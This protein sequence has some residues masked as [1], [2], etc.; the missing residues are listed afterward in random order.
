MT[1]A[2][3]FETLL[4]TSLSDVSSVDELKAAVNKRVL[5]IVNDYED[6]QWRYSRFQSYLWDNIAETALSQRER[7]ALVGKSHTTL[8]ES[9]KNLRLTD[10]DKVGQGSEI[11]EVFLYGVMKDHFGA[12]PVVPKIFYKQ[13][14]QDNAKGADSVHIVIKDNDFTLWFGEAKFYNS[15]A[16]S[17]LDKIVSSVI[18]SLRTDKLKKENSIV[19]NVSD[20][21]TL[22]IDSELRSK[23]IDAIKPKESIDKIKNKINIPIMLLYE[24]S[25]TSS[26][27]IF[28]G[29]YRESLI[30]S[31]KER[32]E[33]YFKKQIAAS[34]S[35]F[36]YKEIRFHVIFFPVPNKEKIVKAFI[37]GVSFFKA[38]S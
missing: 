31:Q 2:I 8:V 1:T 7:N 16:D 10:N 24:C 12:L 22:N 3:A 21:H 35:V 9:A 29:E 5:S 4:D 20:I 36:L 13:N 27:A 15:L 30:S 19:T 25:L 18:E 23:I 34:S 38:Q 33:S 14:A 28:N 32:A 6:G 26:S 17:R 11:A 37:E